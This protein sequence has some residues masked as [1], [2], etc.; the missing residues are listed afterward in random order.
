MGHTGVEGGMA[1]KRLGVVNTKVVPPTYLSRG[2]QV[3]LEQAKI[4]VHISFSAM[5]YKT[6]LD[7]VSDLDI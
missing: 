4:Q 7:N 5:F 6:G 3:Q 2:Y 1:R